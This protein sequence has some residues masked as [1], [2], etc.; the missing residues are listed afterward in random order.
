MVT[1][2]DYTCPEHGRF[3]ATVPGSPD[4]WPC[5]VPRCA[6]PSPWSPCGPAVS[7]P[8]TRRRA[9]VGH[10]RDTNPW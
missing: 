1:V 8:D 9:L 6:L 7:T 10:A 4:E 2:Q 3:E 5:P